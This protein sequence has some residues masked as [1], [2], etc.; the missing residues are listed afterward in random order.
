MNPWFTGRQTRLRNGLCEYEAGLEP[1]GK[2]RLQVS[3]MESCQLTKV[4]MT[5]S[6]Q[7]ATE[8]RWGPLL[9]SLGF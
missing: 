3:N 8:T 5:G 1:A 7:V 2:C 6:V 9:D 4:S